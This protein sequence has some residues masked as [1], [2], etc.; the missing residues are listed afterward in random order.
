MIR[1]PKVPKMKR[2]TYF[3]PGDDED[4]V[5]RAGAKNPRKKR[6]QPDPHG[7]GPAGSRTQR[8]HHPQGWE[9]PPRDLKPGSFP[10]TGGVADLSA[11]T[12]KHRSRGTADT[13][14]RGRHRAPEPG[15]HRK[16]ETDYAGR[17]RRG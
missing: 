2:T 14:H 15:R 1:I 8:P 3:R 9:K 13:S 12:G 11:P 7:H 4:L 16:A 5:Q 6:R 17:H 10:R